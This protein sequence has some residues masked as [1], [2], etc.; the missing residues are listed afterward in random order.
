MRRSEILGLRWC[1]IDL[2]RKSLSVNQ[3]IVD[4]KGVGP[5][6]SEPKTRSSRRSISL[7]SS[8]VA[9]L[10]GLKAKQMVQLK[11]MDIEWD[12][13]YLVFPNSD[14]IRPL[15]PD[16]VSHAFQRIVHKLNL[17]P[18][19]LHDLRHLHATLMLKDGIHPKVVSERL[20]HSNI[21][22]TMD[23]YSH[24]LPSMQEEAAA[25]FERSLKNTLT[26][27]KISSF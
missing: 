1:D 2:Y 15:S 23:I 4:V 9:V 13:S 8:A 11:N 16:T 18:L 20:G 17:P 26:E 27:A 25:I 22:T 14:G 21:A 12:E 19:R 6:E 10:G 3:T 7:P 5:T 24:V